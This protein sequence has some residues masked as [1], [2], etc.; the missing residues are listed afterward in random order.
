MGDTPSEQEAMAALDDL[1]NFLMELETRGLNLFRR[2]QA[3]FPLQSG[4]YTY[5]LANYPLK[6][7]ESRYR[8]TSNL[9]LRMT[10]LRL[11]DYLQ[12]P[13]KTAP[14][15]PIQYAIDYQTTSTI[16]YVWTVPTNITTETI[17]YSYI[18]RFQ[19]CQSLSDSLDLSPE[20]QPTI[21]Y[22]L[23]KRLLPSYGV[24]QLTAQMIV[25]HADE[26]LMRAKDF[27]RPKNVRFRPAYRNMV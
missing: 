24:D 5:T 20:W 16:M 8:N 19:V 1:N 21:V 3:S 11:T 12:L 26:L 6:V 2:T 15:I 14:G 23:A 9:D 13:N 22:G 7:Y 4:V 18:R 17:Q 27:D 25:S 10:E